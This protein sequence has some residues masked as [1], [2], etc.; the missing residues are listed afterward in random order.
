MRLSVKLSTLGMGVIRSP[1]EGQIKDF[2]VRGGVGRDEDLDAAASPTSYALWIQT[3]EG[4]DVVLA[5]YGRRFVSRFK[6]EASPGERIGQG[7]RLGFVYFGTT[8]VVYAPQNAEL[9]PL[10]T[11]A[12]NQ[13]IKGGS[14]VLA[15]LVHNATGSTE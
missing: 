11:S 12:A 10:L 2:W 9:E 8:I 3:D 5:V 1:T 7:K 14:Q 13:R 4:D 15:T 6:A